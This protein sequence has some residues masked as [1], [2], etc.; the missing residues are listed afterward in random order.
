[1]T[2]TVARPDQTTSPEDAAFERQLRID[3]AAT[4]RLADK[5][6]MSELISTHIS[7]RVPGPT[8]A[9]LMNP[10][11]LLFHQ[12]TA[13]SLVKVDFDGNILSLTEYAVPRAGVVIHGAIL[14]ARPDVNCVL[15]AHNTYTI[16]VSAQRDGLLTLSQAAMRFHGQL[17]YHE[18]GRAASHPTERAKLQEDMGDK[19][20]MLLRNHGFLTT[21]RTCG[22]ALISGYFL[23][24]AC[25]VQIT[26]QCAGVPLVMPR[27]DTFESGIQWRGRDEPSWP[28]LIRMLDQEDPS[29]KD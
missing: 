22:E 6:G 20:V 24:R 13:S 14:E 19:W 3:L 21:G 12:I 17:S 4:Y 7:L 29:Y 1:V 16:A 27:E 18:Y 11:G 5:L 10:Y 25:R 2:E 28:A 15:H 8:P 23:D 26:A 9:F